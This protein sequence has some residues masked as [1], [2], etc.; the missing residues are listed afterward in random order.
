MVLRSDKTIVEDSVKITV[1]Y[2][3]DKG[4]LTPPP[5]LKGHE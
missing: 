3:D 5:A 4:Y 1:K 2:L